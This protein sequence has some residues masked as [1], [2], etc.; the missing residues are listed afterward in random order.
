MKSKVIGIVGFIG[1][2]KNTVGQIL[3]DDLEYVAVSFADSLKDACSAIFNW[4]RAMLEG[5]TD[6]SRHFREKVDPWWSKRL[7]IEEFTPRYAL[8]YVGTDVMRNNF[9]K[10]IWLAC[11]ERKVEH[12]LE[13]N[14]KIVITDVR[15]KNEVELIQQLNGEIWHV[16]RENPKWYAEFL[17]MEDKTLAEK[18]AFLVNLGAHPSEYD[19]ITSKFDHIIQNTGNLD[20]LRQSLLFIA[21]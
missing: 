13:N 5:N 21:K 20:Q 15:F 17:T 7:D 19:W 8:Q 9:H 11:V 3:I 12:L 14:K 16:Q 1:S 10:D 4:P 6:L 18:E 2:G